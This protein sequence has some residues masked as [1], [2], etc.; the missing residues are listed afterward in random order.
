[1]LGL[2]CVFE[3]VTSDILDDL[4]SEIIQG[5]NGKTKDN[6]KNATVVVPGSNNKNGS[7]IIDAL[8]GFPFMFNI[9]T[10]NNGSAVFTIG[11]STNSTNSTAPVSFYNKIIPS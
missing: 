1:M 3:K 10:S 4:E 6:G 5:G 11:N 9:S 2:L 8:P 7:E